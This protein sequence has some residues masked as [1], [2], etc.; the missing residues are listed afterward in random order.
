VVETIAEV[1]DEV[2]G[3]VMIVVYTP[4]HTIWIFAAHH[5]L[6]E[7]QLRPDGT[8]M[9]STKGEEDP[10][11]Y[12][13]LFTPDSRWG[14]HIAEIDG[15]GP[16]F[17]LSA[18]VELGYFSLGGELESGCQCGGCG[19]A[20]CHIGFDTAAALSC[21]EAGGEVAEV[22]DTNQRMAS[23]CPYRRWRDLCIYTTSSGTTSGQLT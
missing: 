8:L 16:C 2:P 10:L 9:H 4:E 23:D 17:G 20:S 6:Y 22:V 3:E 7:L 19:T 11:L 12:V 18:Y 5:G 14:W 13:K 15:E 1:G 21:Q